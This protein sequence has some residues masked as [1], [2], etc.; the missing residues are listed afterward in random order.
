MLVVLLSSPMLVTT[1]IRI[2]DPQPQSR[3]GISAIPGC[4]LE[5]EGAAAD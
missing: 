4:G 1:R 5:R 2:Q 3:M